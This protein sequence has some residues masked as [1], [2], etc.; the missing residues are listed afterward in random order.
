MSILAARRP[1]RSGQDAP[2]FIYHPSFEEAGAVDTYDGHPR[3]FGLH[4][5]I[6][7][8]PDVETCDFMARMH[9]AAFRRS[10]ANSAEEARHWKRR[11]LAWRDALVLA[12]IKLVYKAVRRWRVPPASMDDVV[13]DCQVVLL[14]AVAGFNP[15]IGIRFSTYAYTCLIRALSRHSH[16]LAADHLARAI[17]LDACVDGEPRELI[18]RNEDPGKEHRFEE[19][20][21]KNHALLTEREKVV[22]TRRFLPM[23][24]DD[25]HTLEQVGRELGISKERVRQ[26]QGSGLDKLRKALNNIAQ[27]C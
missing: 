23:G 2:A 15:W 4:E 9:Y 17:S 26:L 24:T 13:A 25:V 7:H 6:G 3:D 1:A 27:A 8:F 12:N 10:M 21:Q 22:L 11:Y 18:D 16:R 5:R 19:Y 14:H 20:F